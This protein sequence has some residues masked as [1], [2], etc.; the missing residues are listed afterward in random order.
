MD[1]VQA[2]LRIRADHPSYFESLY[3]IWECPSCGSL[4]QYLDFF[5]EFCEYCGADH[6]LDWDKFMVTFNND[7]CGGS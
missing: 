6:T 7:Y 3:P 5:F 1:K 2:E 4:H